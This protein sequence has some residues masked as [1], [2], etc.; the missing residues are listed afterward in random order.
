MRDTV[1]LPAPGSLGAWLLA[2]RP[3]TLAAALV[4]VMVGSACAL[5]AGGFRAGAALAALLGA[6][7]LQVATNLANDVFDYELGADTAERIGPPRAAERGLLR[8]GALRGALMSCLA[9][10]LGCGLYLVQVAGP[11]VVVIGLCSMV[12]AVAYTAGPY[13]L[14][15]RGLG[16]AFV[17]LFFG[18]VA[19]TGTALVQLGSVP[20]LAWWSGAGVGAIATV[21]LA[22]NNVRDRATD[23]AAGK[24][25]LVVRF[26]RR[27]GELEATACLAVAFAIPV[28]MIASGLAGRALLLVWLPLPLGLSIH[29]GIRRLHGRE[30]N[31]VLG[32]TAVLLLAYGVA[33]AAALVLDAGLRDRS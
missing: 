26:G 13:P 9:L 32:Q 31:R 3:K 23:E 22:V 27:F 29:R 2:A 25:T 18:F 4:P 1:R 33:L 30:L 24:R 6:M 20:A 21:L 28:A 15:Y 12:A 10:A 16:D 5:H 7:C 11:L 14:A 19:V 17:L 8:P